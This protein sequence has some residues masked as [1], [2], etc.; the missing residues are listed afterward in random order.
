VPPRPGSTRQAAYAPIPAAARG[1]A[2]APVSSFAHPK[3]S[4]KQKQAAIGRSSLAR[5]IGGVI[6]PKQFP[7]Y[8]GARPTQPTN[9]R[10]DGTVHS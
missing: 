6:I 9:S 7:L 2:A 4:S 1:A 5:S 8:S 3:Q 10:D